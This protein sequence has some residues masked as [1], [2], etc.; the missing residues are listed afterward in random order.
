MLAASTLEA[1]SG[2]QSLHVACFVCLPGV[3]EMLQREVMAA[4]H[5]SGANPAVQHSILA[6]HVLAN[7][8][9]VRGLSLLCSVVPL[10]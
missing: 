7:V 6:V 10:V 3:F 1:T 9:S 2:E 4:P 8:V 5:A